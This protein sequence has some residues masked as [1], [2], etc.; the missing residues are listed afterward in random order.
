MNARRPGNTVSDPKGGI[1]LLWDESF[2]WAVFA[3]KSLD[4]AGLP[5]RFITA[6]EIRRGGLTGYACLFVPGGWASNKLKA[7]GEEGAGA[8]RQFVADGGAYVGF[9]G[10]AG[11]ATREG[12]G[13][14]EAKRKPTGRRVPS[15]SG[16]IQ[17][18]VDDDPLWQGVHEPVFHAWWPSQFE[19]GPGISVLATYGE[20]L[21]DAFSSDLNVGDT[22]SAG[23]W[24]DL[25]AA[26]GIKLDPR[27]LL[28]D[29][30]VVRSTF[31]KGTV[32]LSLV[33]F[34][35]PG[36]GK[37]AQVLRNLW[38]LYGLHAATER[39]PGTNR[40]GSRLP[41]LEARPSF[42]VHLD[43]LKGAVDG[44]IDL[45]LR[46]FLWF[47]RTPFMLHWRRGVRGLEYNTLKTLVD[48]IR[49]IVSGEEVRPAASASKEPHAGIE[50]FALAAE[51]RLVKVKE[52]LL[53]FVQEASQLLIL[54]RQAMMRERVTFEQTSDP[55]IRAMRERLFSNS[56]S[57][58]G[59][60]K[61]VLDQ[62]DALLYSLL[63][64]EPNL[65]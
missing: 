59:L 8:I 34:D 23:G 28:N 33:H 4:S 43:E 13:L 29:P 46:N 60:F 9:C 17:L 20:A 25:E 3:C 64:F 21:P 65:Q 42:S 57:H 10:G 41:L 40:A 54:E 18:N 26:Y 16:R 55:R 56:K 45:G 38:G 24:A 52:V 49:D 50:E 2:L 7:L 53:P 15:F 30:A 5:F 27:R 51:R 32:L 36:D 63:T 11:L 61:E 39:H 22:L 37:G 62:L 19:V 1:A 58:G 35:S 44:L 12:I 31:G 47:R 48:E 6:E 14:V